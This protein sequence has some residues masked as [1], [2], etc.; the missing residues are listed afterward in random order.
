MNCLKLATV[1]ALA[2]SAALAQLPP[3][4]G[5][6]TL[7]SN[8]PVMTSDTTGATSVYFTPYIG[9]NIPIYNG[10]SFANNTFSQLTMTLNTSNQLSGCIY[11]LFVF[12][13][14]GTVTIGAGPAWTSMSSCS[15]TTRG[16]GAATT[17]LTQLDG[18]W[19]NANSITLTNGSTTYSSISADKATYVGSVYM[20]G[21]GQTGMSF[22]PAAASGGTN[23][24]LGLYNAY[25]RVRTFSK[26]SDSTSS[27]T[28]A[29]ATW[30][31]ADNSA[32]NRI[33]FLDG[34][35]QSVARAKYADIMYT[36]GSSVEGAIGINLD[37][38]S[39]TP[40]DPCA[41]T[42]GTS[43]QTFTAYGNFMPQLGLHY[44]Q[45][46]EWAS[47]ATVTFAGVNIS[48]NGLMLEIDM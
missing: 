39:A 11:D 23:N 42:L 25:N 18:F 24:F 2:A 17:E 31:E 1:F 16:S 27:W 30:R 36:S 21:N 28:Y 45:A 3:P 19:V 34:L 47:G 22:T 40:V 13:N 8:T 26:S 12:L 35:Q 41:I 6:L 20:T 44:A 4:Q 15:T 14:S 48:L 10:T 33:T 43:E 29:T 37:S 9:N 7:T 46:M 38:T 32:S 5:R